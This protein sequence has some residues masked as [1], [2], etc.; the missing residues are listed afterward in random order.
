MNVVTVV[1]AVTVVRVVTVL[2]VDRNKHICKSLNRFVLAKG[3]TK[4]LVGHGS[5]P[6]RLLFHRFYLLFIVIF[7]FFVLGY[8]LVFLGFFVGFSCFLLS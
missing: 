2:T 1:I 5:A 8:F 6:C 3:V 4:H 7:W